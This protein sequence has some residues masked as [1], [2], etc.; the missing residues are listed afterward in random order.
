MLLNKI[1]NF[2]GQN[3]FLT[4]HNYNTFRCLRSGVSRNDLQRRKES[5]ASMVHFQKSCNLPLS[6]NV[7]QLL[8]KNESGY[9]RVSSAA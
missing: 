8:V 7:F 3:W 6:N 1:T 9:R 5:C 2:P 4:Y